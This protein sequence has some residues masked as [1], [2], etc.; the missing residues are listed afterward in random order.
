MPSKI[1]KIRNPLPLLT[2]VRKFLQYGIP[3]ELITDNGPEFTSYD[4]RKFSKSWDFK[5]QTVSRQ[6]H[7]YNGLAE[8]SIQT[9][10]RTLKK[11][12]YDQ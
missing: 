4:F 9:F 3:K 12:K 1:L 7:Q 11:T 10:K 5:H 8:R 2:G 6:Y